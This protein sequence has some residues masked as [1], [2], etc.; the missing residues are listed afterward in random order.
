MRGPV[1]E[2]SLA[3]EENASP[4]GKGWQEQGLERQ[5][6]TKPCKTLRPTVMQ[7]LWKVKVALEDFK[8]QGHHVC[9]YF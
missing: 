4:I 7:I 1:A 3:L 2:I 9:V 8:Q 5:E 6:G